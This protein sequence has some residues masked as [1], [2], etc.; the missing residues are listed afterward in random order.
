M[1]FTCNP[2]LWRLK[3][4]RF[5]AIPDYI[6]SSTLSLPIYQV[7]GQSGLQKKSLSRCTEGLDIRY[8]TVQLPKKY[9]Y[10]ITLFVEDPESTEIKAK[11]DKRVIIP[12]SQLIH[13]QGNSQLYGKTEE[14]S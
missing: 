10:N 11:L 1:A 14:N 3:Q 4:R 7:Q 6:P 8:E 13:S 9:I 5:K 2:G 12:K